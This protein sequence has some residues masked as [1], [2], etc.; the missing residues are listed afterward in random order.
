MALP[1]IDSILESGL[2]SQEFRLKRYDVTWARGWGER[3]LD[4]DFESEPVDQT[5]DTRSYEDLVLDQTPLHYWRLDEAAGSAVDLGSLAD[6]ATYG[7]GTTRQTTGLLIGD[8]NKSVKVADGATS[9]LYI[10]GADV[11]IQTYENY[12]VHNYSLEFWI[13]V[14]AATIAGLGSGDLIPLFG[15]YYK[16]LTGAS[17][18]GSV[19]TE[20][21]NVYLYKVGSTVKL[22]FGTDMRLTA[23]SEYNGS[24]QKKTSAAVNIEADT[25]YHIV[26]VLAGGVRSLYRN[27]FRASVGEN[28]VWA[29][30]YGFISLGGSYTM[31]GEWL[32]NGSAADDR[33][34]LGYNPNRRSGSGLRTTTTGASGVYIDE[35][36]LYSQALSAMEI[37]RHYMKGFDLFKDA[38]GTGETPVAPE[39]VDWSTLPVLGAATD[40]TQYVKRWQMSKDKETLMTLLDLECAESWGLDTLKTVFRS[41]T[42]ITLETRTASH[43]DLSLNGSV[44]WV[45]RGHFLVDGPLDKNTASDGSVVYRISARSPMKLL[46]LD[47]AN[48]VL[49]PDLIKVPR[50]TMVDVTVG[51]DVKEFKVPRAANTPTKPYYENIAP[52]PAPKIWGTDYPAGSDTVQPGDTVRARGSESSVQMLYGEG[53]F[54]IDYDY[55]TTMVKDRGFGNPGEVEIEC[56]RYAT[57]DDIFSYDIYAVDTDV[58]G[59]SNLVKAKITVK[60]AVNG[61]VPT[62][63]NFNGRT[64]FVKSGTAK[65]NIYKIINTSVV[66]P[67]EEMI[68]E[69]S[70]YRGGEIPD[71]IADGLAANDNIQVG[72]ANLAQ[73][74]LTKVF[75]FA[76]FQDQDST[77][78]FY[79]EFVP[80]AYDGNVSVPPMAFNY[81]DRKTY[82]AVIADIMSL[83]PPNYV[84]KDDPDGITRTYNIVQADLGDH[85]HDLDKAIDTTEDA[86]DLNIATRVVAS[87]TDPNPDNVALHSDN[88]GRSATGMYKLT[89]MVDN[90]AN[91]AGVTLAQA[92]ADTISKGFV[93]HDSKTPNNRGTERDGA[94]QYWYGITHFI[95]NT[96]NAKRWSME[97]S[98]IFWIDFGRNENNDKQFLIDSI[99]FHIVPAFPNGTIVAQTITVYYLTEDDY[100]SLTGHIPPQLTTDGSYATVRNH[101]NSA[102]V[103]DAVSWKPLTDE[104]TC[105]DGL[106]IIPFSE[107]IGKRPVR[108]RFMKIQVGQCFHRASQPGYWYGG[109]KHW[110]ELPATWFSMSEFKAYSNSRIIQIAELGKTPPF[111]TADHVALYKRLRRRTEVLENNPYLTTTKQVKDFAAQELQER[112][113]DFNQRAMTCISPHVD[114]YDSVRFADPETGDVRNY[115]VLSVAA[116]SDGPSQVRMVDFSLE[117]V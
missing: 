30:S 44:D 12:Q 103:R 15:Q 57:I 98:D 46:S 24:S 53:T 31:K 55:F 16:G 73:D 89:Q 71:I 32:I 117:L 88:G 107:F 42:Y 78:P 80:P 1:N 75:K 64:I 95:Y 97:D 13:N 48:F 26:C 62:D 116:S 43:N 22:C 17:L 11:G 115:V 86:A 29:G 49:T 59:S 74:C 25:T 27:A 2:I 82:D 83:M 112:F 68:F 33:F 51:V 54:R 91:A 94:G 61:S 101:L 79:F 109:V 45:E 102:T 84:L 93:N 50:T 20:F 35:V 58:D 18:S 36:A 76:G 8:T 100:T 70:E 81:E 85:D 9:Y 52:Y 104:V 38:P 4:S 72:D 37:R 3:W 39:A 40:I 60:D 111:D 41:N 113:I 69:V 65:G 23:T 114:L 92:T 7:A 77:A 10:N 19:D 96:T 14:P 108:C 99:E 66:T 6:N 5:D 106:N 28:P 105:Q 63:E 47:I 56:Y 110:H 34:Y 90:T 87:G 67:N 21:A